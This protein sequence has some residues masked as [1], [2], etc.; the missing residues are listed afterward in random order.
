MLDFILVN[1]HSS[2][3]LEGEIV[4]YIDPFH[5]VLESK[6]ADIILLTHSHYDHFSMEDIKKIAK[7]ETVYIMPQSMISDALKEGIPEE[8]ICF[9]KPGDTLKLKNTAVKTYP[10]YNTNKPMHPKENGWLGYVVTINGYRVYVAGDC[11][12]MPEGADIS[13]DV[14]MIPIGGTYTMNPKEAAEYVNEIAPQ[15][16]IPTHYGSIVGKPEDF[17]EFFRN[18][19]EN[20]TV[21]RKLP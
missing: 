8:K 19:N 15:Y 4:V 11:D 10:S 16:T 7:D 14:A 13:C 12:K 6:D 17:N 9:V 2:V 20:I 3:R 21:I 5:I 18:V 1:E